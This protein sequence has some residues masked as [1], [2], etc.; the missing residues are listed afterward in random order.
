MP[1][2]C[3]D[4]DSKEMVRKDKARSIYLCSKCSESLKYKLMCKTDIKNTYFIS[5]EELDDRGCECYIVPRRRGW[6]DMTLYALSDVLQ[7]F[8]EIHELNYDDRTSIDTK[9]KELQEELRKKKE[10]RAAKIKHKKQNDAVR[11]KQELVAE[12]AKYKLVIRSDSKLCSGY[13]D[14][15]IKDWT[16][17]EIANRMC[18]MKYLFDY[19]NMDACMTEA[20][21]EQQEEFEAGYFPDCSVFEQAE[22]IALDKCGGYPKAWPWLKNEI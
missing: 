6:S 16:I 1:N 12:L 21:E 14:G 15:T 20:Y 13:I 18:E 7:Y 17:E 8:C 3:C 10:L 9:V 11:R 22:L 2:K 5:E 4:C 19:C